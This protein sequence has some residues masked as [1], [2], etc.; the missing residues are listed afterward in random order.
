VP[1]AGS[2]VKPPEGQASGNPSPM[3][4][5]RMRKWIVRGVAAVALLAGVSV[6]AFWLLLPERFAV[7]APIRHLLWGTPGEAPSNEAVARLRAAAGL[8]VGIYA[9]VDN[10][11][12]LRPTPAG[13][14]LV[15]VPREGRIVLLDRDRDG[16]GRSDGQRTLLEELNRPHGMEIHDGWLYVGETDA[17][18]RARFDVE[19]G[20]V[21]GGFERVVTGLPDGGNH[22]TRTVRI[23]PD[24]WLYV[25]VGSS[26]NACIEEDERRAAI[27]RFRPDGSEGEVFAAGLRNAVGFDWRPGTD[28]FYA[29]DNG[30]DLLG[31]D[32][33]PCELNRVVRGGFYGW[34]FANGAR[35][36]DPDHGTGREQ[37]IASSI[38]PAH[39]FRAHNAPLGITFVR[40]AP[41]DSALH[42][43]ALVALHGSWNRTRKDGYEVVSLHWEADGSIREEPFFWGFLEDDRAI[44]R[45]VDVA[46][47]PGGAFY[48]SDDYAG[49]IYRLSSG[50]PPAPEARAVTSSSVGPVDPLADLSPDER[51]AAASR[52]AALY[53]EHACFTCHEAGRAAEG[54]VPAPLGHLTDRYTLR[55]LTAYLATP[56]PPMPVFPLD[57]AQRRDLSVQLLDRETRR[58][59]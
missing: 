28:E 58:S 8:A 55:E 16:D 12:W 47:G 49:I 15:S 27:L 29:T 39:S 41:E 21:T 10:A 17:V 23:G 2:V 14:L 18:G 56:T 57:E 22:W 6:A 13:D 35:E 26:C 38:P 42:G 5:D 48:V 31:D 30:R 53:E 40:E 11:R 33:P 44:G 19:T 45:P 37:E 7:N 43:A 4:L 3:L 1:V 20:T 52:G 36:A 59:R 51:T 46:E 24:G 50:A 9:R 25:S 32:Y 34:P 54:V